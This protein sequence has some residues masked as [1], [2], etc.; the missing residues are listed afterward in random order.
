MHVDSAGLEDWHVGKAPDSRSQ[1]YARRRGYDLS[2][3][4]ARQLHAKDFARFDWLIAMDDG[5]LQRLRAL[6]AHA[7]WHK[8]KPAVQYCQQREIAGVADPYH[9]MEADFEHALDVIEDLCSG[10][11]EAL[12]DQISGAALR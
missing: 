2:D 9:G 4:R 1:A 3:L 7:V 6:C 11:I 12:Q 5:H 10:I 8:I